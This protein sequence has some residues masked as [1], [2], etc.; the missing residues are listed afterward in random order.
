M[1]IIET[2][3]NVQN[4]NHKLNFKPI[5]IRCVTILLVFYVLADI[6]ILQVYAGNETVG[7]PP[8]HHSAHQD[9]H[10][11]NAHPSTESDDDSH[12]SD[13]YPNEDCHEHLSFSSTYII[14]Q[15]FLF[16]P[17]L[18]FCVEKIT[19]SANSYHSKYSNSALTNLFRPPRIA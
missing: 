1:L 18:L 13:E 17:N 2:L 16:E 3:V 19:N 4:L 10:N 15:T 11:D 8:V 7:I 6:T 9:N 14:A 5:V 12:H